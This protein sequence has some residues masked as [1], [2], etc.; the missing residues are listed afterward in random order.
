MCV[1]ILD[2]D[3]LNVLSVLTGLKTSRL[4]I[5]NIQFNHHK[6]PD[7]SLKSLVLSQ[8]KRPD[9]SFV[10]FTLTNVET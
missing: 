8:H 7:S 2:L 1:K 6:H 10:G 4:L 3:S 5:K 9:F